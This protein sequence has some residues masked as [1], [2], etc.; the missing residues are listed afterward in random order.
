MTRNIFTFFALAVLLLSGI[1]TNA[2]RGNDNYFRVHYLNPIGQYTDFYSQGFGVEYGHTF[3]LDIVL[4]ELINPGIDVSFVEL[5]FNKGKDYDYGQE[6]N[7]PSANVEFYGTR[8]GFLMTAGPKVGLAAR[9][10]LVDDLFIS[11]SA[12]YC[13]TLVFGS[14]KLAGSSTY[15]GKEQSSGCF[16]FSNRLSLNLEM[17]FDWFAFGGEVIFGKAN[18][19]YGENIIPYPGEN[20]DLR[21]EINLGMNTVKLYMGFHF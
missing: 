17:K 3:Y 18:L 8:G 10:E 12:K 13:P 6:H 2:Q 20:P 21:D 1:N 16:A 15:G 4:G 14:R 19:K 9:M 11:F 7:L 5:G